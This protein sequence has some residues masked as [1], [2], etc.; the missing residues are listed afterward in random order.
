MLHTAMNV[1]GLAELRRDVALTINGL[2]KELLSDLKWS[3]N[4]LDA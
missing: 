3:L 4:A 2:S 1:M